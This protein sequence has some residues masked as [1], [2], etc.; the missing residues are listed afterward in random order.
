MHACLGGRP[1]S[2]ADL[3]A[4]TGLSKPT[5]RGALQTFQG[6]GLIREYGRTSGR[7]GP[8]ATLYDLVPDV[9]L[10]L[11]IDIG[12]HFVRAALADLDGHA[13]DEWTIPLAHPRTADILAGLR[14]IRGR[15][16]RNQSRTKLAVIGSPGNVDPAT[17]QIADAPNIEGWEGIVA[18]PALGEALGMPV[19]VVNDVNLAALGEQ[20][21][22]RG[23]DVA[24]FAYLMIGSGLGAGIVLDGNLHRGARGAAGEVGLLPVGDDP[25]G[26]TRSDHRGPLETRL[27]ESG[28]LATAQR[29]AEQGP[30]A[31]PQPFDVQAIFEAARTGDALGRAVV[32]ETVRSIA[33]C[34]TA[35]TAIVDLDLVLLGGGI[36]DNAG[37]LLPDLRR[38]VAELVPLPPRIEVASLGEHAVRVGAI[39]VGLDRVLEV[40]IGELVAVDNENA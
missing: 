12:A 20:A 21:R 29:L 35:V 5:V 33:I 39:S 16:G 22:G 13:V 32:S 17:G 23:R 34:V 38:A 18:D 24:N 19:Q 1:F 36:G 6:A 8:S 30:T 11:G 31:I 27:S 37:F 28:I 4:R 9:A 40:T 2:R 10:T 26:A 15:L 7:R 3:A 14:E 25:F